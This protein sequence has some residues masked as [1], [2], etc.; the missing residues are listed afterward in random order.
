M[1]STILERHGRITCDFEQRSAVSR[2]LYK[3][4][5]CFETSGEPIRQQRAIPIRPESYLS[6]NSPV[7]NSVTV[8]SVRLKFSSMD[9]LG[10]I[11]DSFLLSATNAE[12][13]QVCAQFWVSATK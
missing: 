5:L 4:T 2:T 3:V 8:R 9:R 1:F 13:S 12:R 10:E 11:K 7:S 6:S